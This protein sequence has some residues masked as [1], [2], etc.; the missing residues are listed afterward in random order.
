MAKLG[1]QAGDPRLSGT[2]FP[3]AAALVTK[4]TL[5][6]T[7]EEFLTVPAY[8]AVLERVGGSYRLMAT[9]P[10]DPLLN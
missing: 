2:Q 10:E 1:E 3:A 9:A 5:A 8:R 6:P 4:L 7:L